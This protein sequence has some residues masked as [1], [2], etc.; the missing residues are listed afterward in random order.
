M[1]ATLPAERGGH[2]NDN[3]ITLGRICLGTFLLITGV[4]HFIVTEFVASLIPEW[5]PG[6][7]IWWT[8]FAGVALLAGGAGLLVPATAAL[9][10]LLSG[11]MVFSWF[12]I[13]HIP[14][15]FASVSDGLAVFEALA[16]SGIALVIAGFLFARRKGSG[17]PRRV[18][19]PGAR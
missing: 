9:A 10:G 3:Y 5:F 17:P 15:T 16:V 12:W 8:R 11:L 7:A 18:P 14:R 19:A 1:A 2:R 6:N 13:V 4:Q